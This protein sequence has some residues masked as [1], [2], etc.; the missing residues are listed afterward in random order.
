VGFV[1]NKLALQQ[2]FSNFD[3]LANIYST[4]F[5]ILTVTQGRSEVADMASRPSLDS[6]P[7]MR[8]KKIIKGL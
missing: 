1:V 5:S 3:F 7:T 8:I 4:K 2:I 6:T